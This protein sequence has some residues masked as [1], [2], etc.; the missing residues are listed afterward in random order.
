LAAK[1]AQGVVLGKQKGTVQT[2]MYDKDRD[3]IE[4]LPFAQIFIKLLF[5]LMVA[6]NCRISNQDSTKS[7]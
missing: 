4:E 5:I 1:K 3:R 6:R 7:S 2:S